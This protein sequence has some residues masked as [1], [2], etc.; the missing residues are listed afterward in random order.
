MTAQHGVLAGSR[1]LLDQ[2]PTPFDVGAFEQ[3]IIDPEVDP[4]GRGERFDGFDAPRRWAGKDHAQ[5]IVSLNVVGGGDGESF[6]QVNRLSN[7]GGVEVTFGVGWV[8]VVAYASRAVANDVEQHGAD[9]SGL[10][11]S[12]QW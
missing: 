9:D 10:S 11:D 12:A 7:A 5:R 2:T 1:E 6:G 8:V 3:A 4:G